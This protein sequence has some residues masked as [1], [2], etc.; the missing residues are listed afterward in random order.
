MI[1]T[2]RV[3]PGVPLMLLV[4]GAVAFVLN[5]RELKGRGIIISYDFITM[6]VSGGLIPLYMTSNPC[7]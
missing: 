2:L 5:R 1:S 6:F 4:T 3:A 7:D